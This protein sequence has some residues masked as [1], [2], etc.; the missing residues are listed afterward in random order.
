ML[1]QLN[2]ATT[3]KN[4]L[5]RDTA[6]DAVLLLLAES[7][8]DLSLDDLVTRANLDR[9]LAW[10]VAEE[11]KQA[12]YA[13]LIDTSAKTRSHDIRDFLISSTPSGNYFI[14][15]GGYTNQPVKAKEPASIRAILPSSSRPLAFLHPSVQ[16]AS[17]KLFADGH[18]R[19]AILDSFIALGEAVQGK[20]GLDLDNTALMRSAF[21]PKSPV[22]SVSADSGE[23]E[24]F[25]YLYAGAMLAI[26]NPKAHRLTEHPDLQRALE[27]ISFASVLFKVLD[28]SEVI[29]MGKE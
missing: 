23:R 12:G 19:Q 6:K 14:K 15:N 16:K 21:S 4:M 22:L 1:G 13:R 27:W 8:T 26:R 24:G 9:D 25:M 17:G 2:R 11:L 28:D 29:L 10:V 3:P 20:S 18:Y 5:E 7:K